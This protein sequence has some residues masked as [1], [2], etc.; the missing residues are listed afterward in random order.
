M[1]WLLILC[2]NGMINNQIFMGEKGR[3]KPPQKADTLK[4]GIERNE[5]LCAKTCQEY[6]K[7]FDTAGYFT[8]SKLHV[9]YARKLVGHTKLPEM[10][11]VALHRGAYC[12]MMGKFFLLGKKNP[13]VKKVMN[14]SPKFFKSLATNFTALENLLKGLK[15]QDLK[16]LKGILS[17]G[18]T[19]LQGVSFSTNT[20]AKIV[21][22][23][24]YS[25]TIGKSFD[26]PTASVTLMKF[27]A[28]G[29]KAL[30]KVIRQKTPKLPVKSA[31]GANADI[32]IE[33]EE[34][35]LMP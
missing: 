17:S 2:Y 23:L 19:K 16:D 13:R 14:Q 34:E 4:Q 18:L 21:K 33:E 3:R 29:I 15:L 5:K 22:R 11:P 28:K 8:P 12:E 27:V 31:P 24:T 30:D 9:D 25:R 20:S 7:T 6:H 26:D 1:D 35:N 10:G 32:T